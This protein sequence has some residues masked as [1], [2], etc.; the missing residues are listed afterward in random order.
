M[1]IAIQVPSRERINQRL[2]FIFSILTLKIQ[3]G[4]SNVDTQGGIA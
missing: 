2:T 4:W 3:Q 1:K